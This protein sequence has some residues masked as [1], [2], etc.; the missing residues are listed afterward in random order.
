MYYPNSNESDKCLKLGIV[1]I[2]RKVLQKAEFE[3]S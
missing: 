2:D 1:K 3:T